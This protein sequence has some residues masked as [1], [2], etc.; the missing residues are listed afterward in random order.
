[1]HMV[2]VFFDLGK[3]YEPIY[4]HFITRQL[5]EWNVVG[6]MLLFIESFLIEHRLVVHVGDVVLAG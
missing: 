2:T 5:Q 4:R 6:N 3:A 1:M